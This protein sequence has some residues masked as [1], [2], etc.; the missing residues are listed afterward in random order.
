MNWSRL[1]CK[2]L[3]WTYKINVIY[4]LD[5]WVFSMSKALSNMDYT[6]IISMISALKCNNIRKQ[7][8]GNSKEIKI[9]WIT[10][11]NRAK[12]AWNISKDDSNNDRQDGTEPGPVCSQIPFLPFSFFALWNWWSDLISCVFKNPLSFGL[13]LGSAYGGMERWKKR[14]SKVSCPCASSH[15]DHQVLAAFPLRH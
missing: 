8:E 4:N 5:T 9:L 15:S 1:D 11:N 3:L 6:K 12:K 2:V 13:H 14:G 10:L 7:F